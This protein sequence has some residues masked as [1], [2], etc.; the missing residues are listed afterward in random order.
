MKF[1]RIEGKRIEASDS[2]LILFKETTKLLVCAE[3]ILALY[4]TNLTVHLNKLYLHNYLR[5]L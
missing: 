2:G 5:M 4:Y 3:V 1:V